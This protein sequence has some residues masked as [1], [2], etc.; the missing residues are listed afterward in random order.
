MR[1]AIVTGA[2]AAGSLA[3]AA[4]AMAATTA[5]TPACKGAN[6]K[7]T[8]GHVDPGAGQR[9]AKLNFTT[10]KTCVLRIVLNKKFTSFTYVIPG[11]K[12]KTRNVP[13]HAYGDK[14]LGY[15]PKQTVVLKPGKVGHLVIHW[16]VVSARQA[17]PAK[18]KIA[19]PTHKDSAATVKWNQ[20]VGGD[21]RLGLGRLSA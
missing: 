9:Y 11:K 4:P 10:K 7:V 16:N 12:G 17:T 5:A 14:N 8:L 20:L 6:L 15:S 13:V 19:I 1:T 2:V 18:L 3:A 21:F